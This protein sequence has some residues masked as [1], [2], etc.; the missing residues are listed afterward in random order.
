MIIWRA[1][2]RHPQSSHPTRGWP[3]QVHLL[4][5]GEDRSAPSPPALALPLGLD[6][7]QSRM[8]TQL[9][10]HPGAESAV[11]RV[12]RADLDGTLL[13]KRAVLSA[14]STAP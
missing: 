1:L 14:A 7:H 4:A 13:H 8:G 2:V 11:R 9:V 12:N 3:A 5:A 10:H 6:A